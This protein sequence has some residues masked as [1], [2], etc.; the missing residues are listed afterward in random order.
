MTLLKSEDIKDIVPGI[1][2]F[3]AHLKAV[4]G[5]SLLEIGCLASGMDQGTA[6]EILK[7]TRLVCVATTCGEGKIHGF[8]EALACIADHLGFAATI[9]RHT[10]ASGLAEAYEN[11]AHIILTADDNRFIAVNT[12]TCRVV[13]NSDATGM[14]FAV[15]LDRMAGGVNNRDVLVIGCGPVGRRACAMLASLNAKVWVYDVRPEL[16]R[17]FALEIAHESGQKIHIAKDLKQ[18]LTT[19]DI[20][21]DATPAENIIDADVITRKTCVSAPGVPCGVNDAARQLLGSRLMHDPLQIGV[22]TMLMLAIKSI[23]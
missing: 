22:A 23:D 11:Q 20:I 15:G 12:Q 13:D 14:G 9:A 8:V 1:R 19:H 17:D 10:D 16:C 3:D 6:K 5:S 21:L 18:A 7:D 4:S 2:T